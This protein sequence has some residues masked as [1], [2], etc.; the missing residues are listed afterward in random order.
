MSEHLIHSGHVVTQLKSSGVCCSR[1]VSKEEW[2]Q[3]RSIWNCGELNNRHKEADGRN[4]RNQNFIPTGEF[5]LQTQSNVVLYG[6]FIKI[7]SFWY[8]QTKSILCRWI[9]SNV[10]I[11]HTLLNFIKCLYKSLSNI[12]ILTLF[13][14]ERP[15]DHWYIL[16]PRR[17]RCKS[18]F[19]WRP[20]LA[21]TMWGSWILARLL[22]SDW[23]RLASSCSSE[24]FCC[25]MALFS[26]SMDFR[27]VSIVVIWQEI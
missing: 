21:L 6:Q 13:N 15:I 11:F 14:R 20:S 4:N 1:M 5:D 27:L 24:S 26:S 18:V 10:D 9:S 17:G 8:R 12:W 19:G 23:L 16:T 22:I 25:S 7:P 3:H 2:P